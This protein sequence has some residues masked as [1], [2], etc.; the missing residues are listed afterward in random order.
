V[1]DG[2]PDGNKLAQRELPFS[3]PIPDTPDRGRTCPIKLVPVTALGSIHRESAEN[4]RIIT[5]GK[6]L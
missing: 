2:R 1:S 6:D 3:V 4:P 5:V